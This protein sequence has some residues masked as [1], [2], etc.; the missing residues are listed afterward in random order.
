MAQDL[1]IDLSNL[2]LGSV[3]LDQEGIRA[4]IRQR[5]EMEQLNAILWFDRELRL[6]V[7]R[8]DVRSDEFWVRGHIPGR[9]LFPGALM[10]E[11]AA[12][13]S[14]VGYRLFSPEEDARF[15]GFG[16]V[17]DVKFRRAIAPPATLL[18]LG[19]CVELR[20]RRVIFLTQGVED[21]KLAFSATIVGMPIV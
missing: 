11:A 13:L 17:D 3:V 20:N 5:Y 2:D 6:L 12:Q 16:G 14:S 15:V 9:P 1:L 18:L 7:G 4:L 21:G 19:K 10:I 8:K